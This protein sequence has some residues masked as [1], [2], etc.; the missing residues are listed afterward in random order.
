MKKMLTTL[1][2][3]ASLLCAAGSPAHANDAYP[4]RPIRLIVPFSAGG[5][6]DNMARLVADNL[7]KRLDQVITVINR[8]GADNLIAA[9]EVVGSPPDGYTLFFTT[10]GLLSVAPSINPDFPINPQEQFTYIG[11]ISGYPYIFVTSA[12]DNRKSLG[13]FIDASDKEPESVSYA[14]VGNVSAVAG[15]MFTDALKIKMLPVRYKGNA[16]TVTDIFSGRVNLGIFAPSFTLPLLEA[17]KLKP[18]AVTGTN[19]LSQLPDLPLAHEVRPEL[20]A[21]SRSATVWTAI[22]APAGLP[23]DIRNRLEASLKEVVHDQ[24][25]IRQVKQLGDQVVWRTGEETREQAR[26]EREVWTRV[27]KDTGLKIN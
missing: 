7:S 15:A 2:A 10:N 25:F 26:K 16:D 4:S 19:R 23:S 5:P 11:S 12:N 17:Q 20:E 18:L 22:A 13:A 1:A 21:F 24:G 3:A 27:V 6:T 9:R 14:V 8:P